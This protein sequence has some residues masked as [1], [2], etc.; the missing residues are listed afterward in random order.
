MTAKGKSME[1]LCYTRQPKE[2]EIYGNRMAGSMHLAYRDQDG[3]FR[4]FHHN[5]GIL[6]AKAV[7][8][9]S[10]GVLSAR[11]M[12][13]PWLFAMKD[14][15]GVAA[16]R[17]EAEGEKD[18]DSEG[19]ILFFT[20]KDLVHYEEAGLCRLQESGF[21]EEVRCAYDGER[22][23]Y[24]VCWKSEQDGWTEGL[25]DPAD[26]MTVV[27]DSVRKADVPEIAAS[28]VS[29]EEIAL[30]EGVVPGNTIKIPADA[31]EYL[32]KKLLVPVCV[33]M[34]LS[35]H[36]PFRS[37]EELKNVKAVAA[38]SDGTRVERKIDWEKKDQGIVKGRV[39]QEHFP[40]PFAEYRAD[41]VCMYRDGKYYYL[42]TNDADDNHTLYMRC[43]DTLEGIV[44]AEESLFLD[45]DTYPGIGGL[46]WAPE[47]HEIDGKLYVFH[48]A[49][50]GEF[51]HEES[52]VRKLR[53]GGDPMCRE[54]WS[55]PVMVVKKDGTPLCEEGKVISLDMTV[56]PYEGKTYAM[57]SQRQ[58][59][60]VDQGAWLYLAQ[61]DEKEPWKLLSDPVCIAKPEYGWENNHT[62][63]VEGPFALEKNGQLMITYAAAAVD[64]TYTVGLLKPVMGSDILD[65]DNWN[66]NNYP[67]MSS[68][69][70]KG[71]YGPGHNSYV[72]DENGLVWNFYH[73]RSGVDGPRSSAARRTHFDV[74]GEPMLDVTEELDL[75]ERFRS[76][77]VQLQR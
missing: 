5:E 37:E 57:W 8:D 56:F 26:G 32:S 75:P 45:S 43:S 38:Y 29:V 23:L 42:A 41:P 1:L 14:G 51:F 68:N 66:K 69:S 13:S 11:S 24:K 62:Y 19:C 47:F 10:N 21:I 6:Y 12:K 67:L 7:E 31:G 25:I 9:P 60:P 20:S 70:V 50:S 72:T 73:M 39:H 49:T 16:V 30:L 27:S 48:A 55:E 17:T 61:I 34:E 44:T 74:D 33:G 46:L 76:F 71:Q 4:P 54:D 52:R 28:T 15:Y 58:F 35:E 77:E 65:P 40:A 53:E 18:A 22:Q 63:V 59:L 36:G 64:A 2:D 3:K